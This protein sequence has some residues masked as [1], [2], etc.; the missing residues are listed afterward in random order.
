[1]TSAKAPIVTD[2]SVSQ[3]SLGN[4]G[5]RVRSSDIGSFAIAVTSLDLVAM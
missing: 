1:M 4:L 3:L 5:C 2:E